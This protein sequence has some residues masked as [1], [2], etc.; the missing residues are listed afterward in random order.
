MLSGFERG[1]EID[2]VG[3]K[4]FCLR[5]TASS[6]STREFFSTDGYLSGSIFSDEDESVEEALDKKPSSARDIDR[7][8]VTPH[9]AFR[10]AEAELSNAT[11]CDTPLRP[12]DSIQVGPTRKRIA[13][14]LLDSSS[15][16]SD[17]SDGDSEIMPTKG[18]MKEIKGML[19]LLCKKVEDN[20]R[21]LT[22]LHSL[23]HSR[24]VYV[25]NEAAE[26]FG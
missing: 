18:E 8:V 23:Y 3:S 20:S 15:A 1:I 25:C 17:D 19:K 14:R 5:L 26:R 13:H 9:T 7:A 21:V 22:E 12:R 16:C 24:L 10:S 4:R 2:C 6:L 11:D